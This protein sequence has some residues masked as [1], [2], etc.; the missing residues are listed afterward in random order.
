MQ[1]GWNVCVFQGKRVFYMKDFASH[2]RTQ[3][4]SLAIITLSC[5]RK[6]PF[7]LLAICCLITPL[8]TT[9]QTP[10]NPDSALQAL[11]SGISGTPL[12]LSQAIQ[13]GLKNSTSFI[14]AE[15]DFLAAGGAERREAGT[16]DP[17]L[18]FNL[19]Y[20]NQHQPTASFFAGASTLSTQ[21]TTSQG[22]IRIELPIGTQLALAINTV[23]LNTNSTF[24]FLNPEYDAFGSLTLRQPLLGGF[25]V[26]ARKHLVES[27]R[28]LEAAKARFDQEMIAISADIERSYWDLYQ[29]E[30]D[31]AVQ[32]LTRD[33]AEAFLH[34]TE[35]RAKSG[36]VGPNQV[37]N[38]KTF[39]A[40]QDLELIDRQ[41]HL[42]SQSDQLASVIGVRPE[43]GMVR[44][45][46]SD[47]PPS[48]YPLDPVDSLVG[49][50]IHDNLDLHAAQNEIDAARALANAAGWEALPSVNLIGSLG[51]SGLAGTPQQVIVLGDTLETTVN[52]GFSDALKQVTKRDF[53]NWSVGVEVSIPIGL[54]SGLGE[55][56]RLE[57]GVLTAEQEYIE[58]SRTLEAQIRGTFRELADGK[59]RL[60]VA[61]EGVDAAQEQVRI[62]MIE[63]ENG[64]S[65]AF[66][67]VR[68]GEDFAIAQQRYSEALVRTAKAA[69]TLRQ[70]TSGR[71]GAHK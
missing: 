47:E 59:T 37:A 52:G 70:L 24:A 43:Q 25:T 41:E 11:L 44:F 4:L 50:A 49:N 10:A 34:E 31:Y 22:G 38:A 71:Y 58:K 65:T 35:L 56:D 45:I 3:Y 46:P 14:K 32:K 48:D 57:A 53:P 30:R 66:E 55:K 8:T 13:Y 39:L 67:L 40:Q 19:N 23:K 21:Q 17:Q 5:M 15:A 26:S 28:E 63:F 2:R 36:L 69:A 62:G 60:E 18:F 20:L 64:R 51:G 16:F 33:R 29:A 61:R 54:R 68:L 7:V 27:E 1:S 42:D 9:G 12:G 6:Y